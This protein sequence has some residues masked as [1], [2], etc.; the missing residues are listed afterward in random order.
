MGRAVPA[1]Q[2]T[3]PHRTQDQRQAGC[4]VE[5]VGEGVRV[6]A[7]APLCATPCVRRQAVEARRLAV[8]HLYGGPVDGPQPDPALKDLP[9]PHPAASGGGSSGARARR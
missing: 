5:V 8:G 9:R 4:G 2:Q 7:V 6:S 1:A 3:T